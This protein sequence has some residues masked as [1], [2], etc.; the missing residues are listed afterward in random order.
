MTET[1]KAKRQLHRK[2]SFPC[3]DRGQFKAYGNST[4]EV[5]AAL[6]ESEEKYHN[7]FEHSNDAIFVHDLDG[8]IVDVNQ[9]TLDLFGYTK[10]QILSLKLPKLHPDYA[11]CKSQLAF[12]TIAQTGSVNF[13]IDFRK[14]N[15]SIFPASVSSSLFEAGGKKLIQGMVCDITRQRK[16]EQIQSVLF[17]ITQATSSAESLRELLQIIHQQLG[18]L[19]DTTNFYVALY[20]KKSDL[21]SFPFVVDEFEQ[22]D[23][24]SPIELKKSLTDYVR[25]TGRAILA[26]EDVHH[27]L[28]VEG[29]VELVGASSKVWMGAPLKTPEGVIG[30]V[31]VQS[32]SDDAIYSEQDMELLSYI[33]EHIAMAIN[34][35]RAEEKIKASLK[36]KDVLLKEIHHRV[37]NNMQIISSLIRLQSRDVEDEKAQRIFEI[38]Q[39]R[40][41]SIALIH[42]TLYQSE[43]LSQIDFS[44][45]IRRLT[46]HLL[47]VYRPDGT[48]H[49]LNLDVPEV[50]LDI[51]RAIPCGLIINELVSNVMKHAFP[52]D[53]RGEIYV[54]FAEADG[55]F[56]LVVKDNGEGFPDG[57]DFRT[58]DSLGLQIVS[59]LVQQLEG[60]IR[61]EKEE[62]T[63]FII[64]F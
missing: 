14:K 9:K 19:I 6:K 29:E 57:L 5:E 36:E 30:V 20:D 18:T 26:D 34:R 39:N 13:E 47:S 59:D 27:K 42:E 63:A 48:M 56:T 45:Y 62:G 22:D 10:S 28:I 21:Y 43:D 61:L 51:N 52:L 38:S 58:T 25:R 35:K 1:K 16:S 55:V 11:L 50:L 23:T 17:N 32:Y 31:V 3:Q 53:K 4:T 2:G 44:N 12:E 64:S 8:K 37:K 7:L 41:R 46:T 24:F 40:I 49:R 33:S 54:R 15:G 60:E